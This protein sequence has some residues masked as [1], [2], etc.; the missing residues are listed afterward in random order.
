[1]ARLKNKRTKFLLAV[2]HTIVNPF[3]PFGPF[4]ALLSLLESCMSIVW[5]TVESSYSSI[6]T[7]TYCVNGDSHFLS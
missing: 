6:K 2:L 7:P 3:S 5:A 4:R 1:M